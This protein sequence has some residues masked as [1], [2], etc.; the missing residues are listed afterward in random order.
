[1]EHNPSDPLRGL[2]GIVI[3]AAINTANAAVEWEK[4]TGDTILALK[5]RRSALDYDKM[6]ETLKKMQRELQGKEEGE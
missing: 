3:A 5:L 4:S 2:R 1:M 6:N